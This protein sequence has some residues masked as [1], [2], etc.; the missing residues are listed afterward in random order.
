MAPEEQANPI[1]QP[2]NAELDQ[3]LIQAWTHHAN[4]E[5]PQ[6][7]NL[8]HKA[9]QAYPNAEEAAYGLGL[10]QKLNDRPSE[11][12]Q[13][14]QKAYH[15]LE[16]SETIQDSARRTMLRRLVAAHLSMLGAQ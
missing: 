13:S 15:L 16:H 12:I 3:W 9:L 6:A 5:Y 11:A 2:K 4:K 14:F 1:E 7:E 10:S 8:F